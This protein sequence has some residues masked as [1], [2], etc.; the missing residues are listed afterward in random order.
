MRIEA[1]RRFTQRV[2]EDEDETDEDDPAWGKA[3]PPD[4]DGG[5][6]GQGKRRKSL[7]D[8]LEPFVFDAGVVPSKEELS[9]QAEIAI[10]ADRELKDTMKKH[11]QDIVDI[12][13]GCLDQVNEQLERG[14]D[15]ESK[16]R[17]PLLSRFDFE[18]FEALAAHDFT[19]DLHA[20]VIDAVL[21]KVLDSLLDL[22]FKH[23]SV[24]NL[25]KAKMLERYNEALHARMHTMEHHL[26]D[27]SRML[28]NC[29]YAYSREI[30][31]LRAQ[32]YLMSAEGAKFEPVEAYFFDPCEFLDEEFRA[33][34]NDKIT[35]SVQVYSRRLEQARKYI[36]ELED[37]VEASLDAVAAAK[38]T[39]LGE[40]LRMICRKHTEGSTID[41]MYEVAQKE[42]EEWALRWADSKG[43]V[44]REEAE[45]LRAQERDNE[46][47]RG[48]G[49]AEDPVRR[50]QA[51]QRRTAELEAELQELRA[52]TAQQA[53]QA[54]KPP[55]DAANG[56]RA[57][58]VAAYNKQLAD[59]QAKLAE[60]LHQVDLFEAAQQAAEQDDKGGD[61]VKLQDYSKSI[62]VAR[63]LREDYCAAS[64][65]SAP[66]TDEVRRGTKAAAGSLQES[67]E[68][69]GQAFQRM[70]QEVDAKVEAAT[71][72]LSR[73]SSIALAELEERWQ[74]KLEEAVQEA[75][76]S[77]GDAQAT[78][79]PKT[80]GLFD[81]EL[82]GKR[83][84]IQ[85]GWETATQT[86]ITAHG[87]A[88]FYLLEVPPTEA[89]LAILEEVEDLNACANG[90]WETTLEQ[91]RG[92]QRPPAGHGNGL[93]ARGC[94]I[95]LFQGARQRLVRH[96]ELIAM[97]DILKRAELEQM[98]E[99]MQFLMESSLPDEDVPL[100]DT[101]FGRGFSQ[102]NLARSKGA[103]FAGLSKRWNKLA[104]RTV[105]E[106]LTSKEPI[107]LGAHPGRRTYIP[108][109]GAGAQG[110][111]GAGGGLR[112]RQ[113]KN[114]SPGPERHYDGILSDE[115][116][117]EEC[118]FSEETGVPPPGDLLSKL[119]SQTRSLM[120]AG[121]HDLSEESQPGIIGKGIFQSAFVLAGEVDAGQWKSADHEPRPPVV[122]AQKDAKQAEA[123]AE[124][125]EAEEETPQQ[126]TLKQRPQSA[127]PS[128]HTM[129]RPTTAGG[130]R[131]RS[132]YADSRPSTAG[133]ARGAASRAA[134]QLRPGSA[135]SGRENSRNSS[136]SSAPIAS[137][138]VDKMLT[139][140]RRPLSAPS[141]VAV[142]STVAEAEDVEEPQAEPAPQGAGVPQ[143]MRDWTLDNAG[144]SSLLEKAGRGAQPDR[145][146]ERLR[147]QLCSGVTGPLPTWEY[148]RLQEQK[149]RPVGGRSVG[150]LQRPASAARLSRGLGRSSS[151]GKLTGG[152]AN[153]VAGSGL[154]SVSG[155]GFGLSG[156]PASRPSSAV[157]RSASASRL[158]RTR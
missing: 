23:V 64:D 155:D 61:F 43:M 125:E 86:N 59:L 48:G 126:Q 9:Q 37:R 88:G 51:E 135:P 44:P 4:L 19:I 92:H 90:N 50:L 130:S 78:L 154:P 114:L 21:G 119:R 95:R 32:V 70:E 34:L 35:L 149:V 94:F 30:N 145:S 79:R 26:R 152:P 116:E 112:A 24:E 124:E 7:S 40:K 97:V 28:S 8:G 55:L 3:V 148:E 54:T 133:P 115:G 74:R 63:K 139:G 127:T 81:R 14:E 20:D 87:D 2:D 129:S 104:A 25:R 117:E 106:L 67:I 39:D 131:P 101:I 122:G 96:D 69:L 89:E 66:K 156:S 46:Q 113:R 128:V 98:L 100:R 138:A 158:G 105:E 58:E 57:D 103:D 80:T 110:I 18:D 17:F 136:S 29:R 144:V 33:Q 82:C 140:A 118:I 41:S 123:I 6:G 93:C 31:H 153:P 68:H 150:A 60:A 42:M 142:T 146:I 134:F 11:K 73:Q 108:G 76:R 107:A 143:R 120:G 99:G 151:S 75:L 84:L 27:R 91:I 1:R 56:L 36:Q 49:G 13:Q 12:F 72:E 83:S 10:R 157:G 45:R 141:A 85:D 38:C 121:F 77:L 53:R 16:A 147:Q 137:S 5:P 62:V 65:H 102:G 22:V 71:A 47:A 15:F 111:G 132:E 52:R 109:G